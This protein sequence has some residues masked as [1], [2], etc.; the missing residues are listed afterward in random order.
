MTALMQGSLNVHGDHAEEIQTLKLNMVDG[1]ISTRVWTIDAKGIGS[2]F[3]VP[4]SLVSRDEANWLSRIFQHGRN[5]QGNED[6]QFF[7]VTPP[8]G[9]HQQYQ[10]DQNGNG[11]EP[12]HIIVSRCC[13]EGVAVLLDLYR[14]GSL[15][16]RAVWHVSAVESVEDLRI[17]FGQ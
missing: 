16:S 13:R 12:T 4:L 6:P 9:N 17:F 5:D 8:P 1:K 2:S 10:G 3:A 7:V 14:E 15:V 11:Q